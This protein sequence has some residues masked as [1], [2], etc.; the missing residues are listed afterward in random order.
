MP[1]DRSAIRCESMPWSR[2]SKV[3]EGF[4]A[5]PVNNSAAVRLS[6][7]ALRARQLFLQLLHSKGIAL[8]GLD[9]SRG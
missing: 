2:Y 9:S 5:A 3:V 6:D 7:A 4:F 1:V 8:N